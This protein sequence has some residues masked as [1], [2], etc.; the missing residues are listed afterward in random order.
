[1]DVPFKPDDRQAIF[2]DAPRLL[3]GRQLEL[4]QWGDVKTLS[5]RRDLVGFDV[6][7]NVDEHDLVPGVDHRDDQPLDRLLP[8]HFREDLHVV[9]FRLLPNIDH[10]APTPGGEFL[11]DGPNPPQDLTPIGIAN[12]DDVDPD[13]LEVAEHFGG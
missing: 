4:P 7:D 1:M 10:M 3:G 5:Q 12:F 9:T 2:G 13:M 6:A 8:P 11:S